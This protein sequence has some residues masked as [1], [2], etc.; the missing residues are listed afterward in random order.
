MNAEREGEI[1]LLARE[2]ALFFKSLVE[3]GVPPM[4][5]SALTG[6]WILSQRIK[7]DQSGE[8]WRDGQ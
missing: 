5:A 6:N 3:G 1:I 7:G 2:A 8:E 4:H